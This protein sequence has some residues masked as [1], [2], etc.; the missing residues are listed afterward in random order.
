MAEDPSSC[1]S[2]VRRPLASL[3]DSYPLD[4][5]DLLQEALWHDLIRDAAYVGFLPHDNRDP[6]HMDPLSY[7]DHS[8]FPLPKNLFPRKEKEIV[9]LWSFDYWQSC[10]AGATWPNTVQMCLSV[11][12]LGSGGEH[13]ASEVCL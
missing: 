11:K 6:H 9:G 12:T 8:A 1:N 3:S 10:S 5:P 2:A 7:Q 4:H 13:I